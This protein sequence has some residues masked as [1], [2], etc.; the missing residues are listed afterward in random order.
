VVGNARSKSSRSSVVNEISVP[1]I[2]I[3]FGCIVLDKTKSFTFQLEKSSGENPMD[4]TFC[5]FA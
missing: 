3:N 1:Q 5:S 4:R 2:A